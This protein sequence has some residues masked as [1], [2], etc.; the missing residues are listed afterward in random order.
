MRGSEAGSSA[1]L[2]N[3]S[4]LC[5]EDGPPLPMASYLRRT[6]QLQSVL[7]VPDIYHLVLFRLLWDFSVLGLEGDIERRR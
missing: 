5:T 7:A 3:M 4:D 2:L 6:P 1:S